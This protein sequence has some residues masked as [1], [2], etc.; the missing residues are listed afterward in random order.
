M[1]RYLES[2]LRQNPSSKSIVVTKTT[3]IL[4]Y[5]KVQN[6]SLHSGLP[7]LKTCLVLIEK[8]EGRGGG[9]GGGGG[10]SL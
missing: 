5:I 6:G 9:G 7:E 2:S 1:I 8:E 10:R 4:R 3:L